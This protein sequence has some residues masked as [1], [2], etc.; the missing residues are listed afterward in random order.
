M[1]ESFGPARQ[2]L[3]LPIGAACLVGMLGAVA[4]EPALAQD[5]WR[6]SLAGESAAEAR[7][8]A[9]ATVG[10]YNLKLGPT[11]WRFN[12]GLDLGWS[13]NPNLLPSGQAGGDFSFIPQVNAEMWWPITDRNSLNF[14]M[15]VGYLKYL[16]FSKLDRLFVTPGSE[17]AFDVFVGNFV[18]NL[19][20]RPS[21]TEF[22]YQDPTV[23]GTGD[24]SQ[25]QNVAGVSAL[26]DLNKIVAR[27]GY[28][29][30][31]YISLSS[32]GQYPD[33]QEELFY[34]NAG[35]LLKPEMQAG[36]ES[37]VSLI[38]YSGFFPGGQVLTRAVQWN[39]GGFYRLRLSPYT[40]LK[41]SCGYTAFT[42]ENGGT[43]VTSGESSGVYFQLAINHR[44][45][46]YLNYSLNAGRALDMSFFAGPVAQYF[47]TLQPNWNLFRK[48][49]LS[50]PVSYQHGSYVLTAGSQTFDWLSAGLN[51]SRPITQKLTAGFGYQFVT[52]TANT[53]GQDYTVNTLT[54]NFRY[55]F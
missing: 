8:Q 34:A 32:T 31:N 55:A 24:Y 46:Q 2:W 45:N 17:L 35:Y 5:A 25:F 4:P 10:Y 47:V 1:N 12:A 9:N 13:D 52:R 48:V 33:G 27:F 22:A 23:S 14:A 26:W 50:T 20:D 41:A 36:V 15:G 21:I 6:V 28:D 39:G 19:H 51:V 30:V 53:P 54:L 29:H 42:P 18:I 11:A 3:R 44:V 7:K 40:E 43:A 49:T 38:R 37:G 16:R